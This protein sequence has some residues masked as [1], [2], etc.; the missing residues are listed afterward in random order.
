MGSEMAVSRGLWRGAVVVIA[1]GGLFAFGAAPASAAEHREVQQTVTVVG[2]GSSVQ[3]SSHAIQAGSIRFKV[4]TTNP[5][6][7]SPGG[8]QQRQSVSA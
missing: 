3:L 8:R 5:P 1:A 2:N 4:S 6:R 7:P